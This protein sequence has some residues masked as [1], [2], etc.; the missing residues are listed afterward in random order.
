MEV[1]AQ[2]EIQQ[3]SV[4]TPHV[5]IVGAGASRAACPGGDANGRTLPLM[6]D[7]IEFVPVQA[8]LDEFGIEY[9]GDNFEELYSKLASDPSLREACEKLERAIFQYFDELEL[10]EGPNIYD[11]LLL[12]LRS[13]DVIATFNW[14]PFLI[15]SARRLRI[16]DNSLPLLLFLHGNVLAGY[17][18]NDQVHGVRGAV[19]SRC[20]QPFAPSSLL[21]PVSEKDYESNPMISSSWETLSIALR[22][23]FMVTVFGYSAPAADVSASQLLRAAW[24][25][26]DSRELEQFEI[27]DIQSEADLLHTWDAFI[28][29]H[30]FEVHDDIFDSWMLL[31]PRRTGEAFVN[32]YIEA[33]FIEDHPVPRDISLVQLKRWFQPLLDAETT[34][35]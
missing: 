16:G 22:N 28:H 6:S 17:C 11:Y 18:P 13:K 31:H 10:P 23:A 7:F 15:Q 3:I 27:I 24:G 8:I 29:T 2:Q 12:S 14:D 19:C 21:Y 32:Q 1:T 34:A 4:S 5:V 9:T 20:G 25:S 35:A 33:L 30:H 26:A